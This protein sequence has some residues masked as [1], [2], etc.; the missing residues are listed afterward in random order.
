MASARS[1]LS[2]APVASPRSRSARLRRTHAFAFAGLDL[3]CRV[4]QLQSLVVAL[5]IELQLRE[6]RKGLAVTWTQVQCVNIGDLGF[7]PSAELVQGQTGAVGRLAVV[8]ALFPGDAIGVERLIQPVS[9]Q[10]LAAE[11]EVGVAG[12][13][14]I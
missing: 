6:I 12:H 13:R 7:F 2:S 4:R 11:V 3:E 8:G 5:L 10:Q 14:I 1:M 9:A